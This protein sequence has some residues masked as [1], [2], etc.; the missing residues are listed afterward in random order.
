MLNKRVLL[1]AP[2]L[3]SEAPITLAMLSAVLKEEGFEVATAVNT[4]KKPMRIQDFVAAAKRFN[5]SI[6]GINMLTFEVLFVYEL[7][8]GLKKNGIFVIVGGPHPTDCPQEVLNAGADVVIQGE[9]EEVL[10]K[11]VQAYPSMPRGI[12]NRE[13]PIDPAELPY[14]DLEVFDKDLFMGD[15]GLVKGFH[16]IY[17]SRGCPGRCTFCDWQVFKQNIKFYPVPM[18]IDEIQSRVQRYGITSFSIADDC[19]TMNKPRVYEFCKQISKIRPKVIWRAN[20]R[21]NLVDA[22]MLRAMRQAGC[23]LIAFGFESGDAE[24]LKRVKKHVTVEQNIK[25]AWMAHA[26]GLQVYG[27]MMTG[28]PWETPKHVQSNIDFIH[29]T[30]EAVSLYQVSGS[31]MPFPGS[32]IYQEYAKEYGF[33]EYWLKPEHQKAGIQ[34][35]QNAINPLAVSVLYQRYFFDDTYIQ[36]ERFF[37]YTDAYKCK[38]REMAEEI[39]KH[40]LQ[41]MFNG[42]PIKRELYIALS[43]LSM[44]VYDI[45]PRL[46][47]AI[48]GRLYHGGRSSVE[49]LRDKRRGFVKDQKNVS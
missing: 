10:R 14:P 12:M 11:V 19:F 20:S 43:K 13:R 29:K 45:N 8:K 42:K 31:L 22:D 39:G 15:D 38:V 25:A 33:E 41:F 28:F 40:N 49:N 30:W 24:T 16:R 17:T 27:C 3:I 46:E 47:M 9:G 26:E 34:I 36:E 18:V 4:F 5:A 6:V 35:Y 1:I 21:A 7:I 32:E 44:K 23:H 48:G 2:T 37:K